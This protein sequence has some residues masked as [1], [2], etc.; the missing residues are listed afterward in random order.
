MNA[1][2]QKSPMPSCAWIAAWMVVWPASVALGQSTATGPERP[3]GPPG[4][5]P[6]IAL[7]SQP[8][9]RSSAKTSDTTRAQSKSATAAANKAGNIDSGDVGKDKADARI[10]SVIKAKLLESKAVDAEAINVKTLGGTVTLSGYAKS[11]AE[12]M[13]AERLAKDVEGVTAIKNTI[14]V[15]Q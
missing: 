12:K 15:R 8:P 4:G 7:P 1:F 10:D 11:T 13:A 14:A 9:T 6:G 5:T 2:T 3:V